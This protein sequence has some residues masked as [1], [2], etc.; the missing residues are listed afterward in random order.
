MLGVAVGCIGLSY[1]EFCGIEP[2]EFSC[3]YEAYNNEQTA[4]YRDK[5]ERMRMLA[6]ITIQPH[7]KNRVIPRKLLE[8]PWEKKTLKHNK[9][10][11]PVS[12]EDSIRRFESLLKRAKD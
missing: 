9:P 4:Q 12:K 8:F 3:I 10:L 2:R 5:W 7:V 1:A 11:P 6:S